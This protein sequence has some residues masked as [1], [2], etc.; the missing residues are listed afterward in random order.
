[1]PW[2]YQEEV[3]WWE[4]KKYGW[5]LERGLERVILCRR[6]AVLG[7]GLPTHFHLLVNRMDG[8]MT[9]ASNWMKLPLCSLSKQQTG[10][11]HNKN[12]APG[13]KRED[14]GFATERAPPQQYHV[15]PRSASEDAPSLKNLARAV[16]MLRLKHT[17]QWTGQSHWERMEAEESR[18]ESGCVCDSP[19]HCCQWSQNVNIDVLT[20]MKST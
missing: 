17:R 2:Q 11:I 1:M 19:T 14:V 10:N 3:E 15:L 8:R 9:V 18:I 6:P 7:T 16:T 20:H 4:W 12:P 5:L 13:F